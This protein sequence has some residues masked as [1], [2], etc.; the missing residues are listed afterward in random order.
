MP[1]SGAP[2]RNLGDG[3]FTTLATI[4]EEWSDRFPGL[5]R[6]L[7][8]GDAIHWDIYVAV[9]NIRTNLR[10]YTP[11]SNRIDVVVHRLGSDVLSFLVRNETS[12]G[13]YSG[14]LGDAL[15]SLLDNL[16]LELEHTYQDVQGERRRRREDRDWVLAGQFTRLNI[17][18]SR[19]SRDRLRSWD[20]AE[21]L[22]QSTQN[23][24]VSAPG[25]ARTDA[26][27]DGW[28]RAS[29]DNSD[30]GWGSRLIEE[31]PRSSSHR[32]LPPP[33][34]PP[35]RSP[36]P[37]PRRPAISGPRRRPPTP[38]P[39]R[40]SNA[41]N[42]HPS[43]PIHRPIPCPLTNDEERT[44]DNFLAVAIEESLHDRRCEWDDYAEF[45]FEVGV[46]AQGET[47]NSQSRR[48]P[49]NLGSNSSRQRRREG[50]PDS[51]WSWW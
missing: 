49:P 25:P 8:R 14:S 34:Q 38:P 19:D 21:L 23:R 26:R 30:D 44:Y 36:S 17:G 35:S 6:R 13:G 41:N 42:R 3:D 33:P 16:D 31:P 48:Q 40:R 29:D 11:Q 5:R 12:S 27:D 37:P 22:N 4:L 10:A 15:R 50:A 45:C 2:F 47:P 43:R 1:R 39:P 28:G 9:S 18:D 51:N 7:Y 24:R 20:D 46:I 32:R